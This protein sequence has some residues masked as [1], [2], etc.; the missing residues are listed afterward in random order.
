MTSKIDSASDGTAG[1]GESPAVAP[2]GVAGASCAG[3]HA[4]VDA[5]V[6]AGAAAVA[7]VLE[8]PNGGEFLAAAPSLILYEDEW[9]LAAN[10]PAG[11]IVHADGTGQETLTDLV[12]E[13]LL[14]TG[15]ASAMRELQA[16][17][18]LDRET[19]GVVLFSKSKDVQPKLD[20][21]VAS[22]DGI[23]KRYLAIV[24]GNFPES[25]SRIDAPIARDRHDARRMRTDRAGKPSV[26]LVRLLASTGAR[27]K[28]LSLVECTLRT[29]RKHQIRVHLA[30]Q[31]FPILGDALYGVPADRG[32]KTPLMLHAASEALMHPVTGEAFRIASCYPSRFAKFFPFG[33]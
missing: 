12:R 20:A 25:L 2:L 26:T 13:H 29:G 28:R 15:Q 3:L 11:I 18:R 1:E 33:G 24:R 7:G 19:S 27:G 30:S 4:A 21:L 16:V 6:R 32:G 9:L 31:G 14:A 8:N 10:K 5:D 23:E 22:H 17:Q